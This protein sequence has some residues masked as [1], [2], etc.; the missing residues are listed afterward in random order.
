MVKVEQEIDEEAEITEETEQNNTNS[1]SDKSLSFDKRDLTHGET[2]KDGTNTEKEKE[3]ESAVLGNVDS[4]DV[5]TQM[6]DEDTDDYDDTEALSPV[7]P[8]L[9]TAADSMAADELAEE[10]TMNID[11]DYDIITVKEEQSENETEESPK[12][13]SKQMSD[14]KVVL[15]RIK[16]IINSNQSTKLRDKKSKLKAQKM[17][18]KLKGKGKKYMSVFF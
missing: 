6:F 5:D 8:K 2:V 14:A 10:E 4:A 12:S 1:K 18:K 16:M 13:G 3:D 9:G 7:E 11:G 17:G 15:K